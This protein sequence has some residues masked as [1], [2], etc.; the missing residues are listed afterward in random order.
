MTS[1]KDKLDE[2]I[3]LNKKKPFSGPGSVTSR[4]TQQS[5]SRRGGK[6]NRNYQSNRSTVLIKGR[7]QGQGGKFNEASNRNQFWA[8]KQGKFYGQSS[9]LKQYGSTASLGRKV[10]NAAST[11]TNRHYSSFRGRLRYRGQQLARNR[12]RLATQILSR[13]QKNRQQTL[14]YWNSGSVQ[15]G[16]KITSAS[17]GVRGLPMKQRRGLQANRGTVNSLRSDQIIRLQKQQNIQQKLNHARALKSNWLED[18]NS[19]AGSSDMLTVCIPNDLATKRGFTPRSNLVK[20]FG[21]NRNF[22]G[23]YG[24]GSVARRSNKKSNNHLGH[25]S[26]AAAD[27]SSS[28]VD[29][30]P[31]G[32]IVTT[33]S[34]Y[35]RASSVGRNQRAGSVIRGAKQNRTLTVE[36]YVPMTNVRSALN[37]QLQ[38]EIA[39]IQGKTFQLS[40]NSMDITNHASG[41]NTAF[42]LSGFKPV[43]SLTATT[44]NER[45]SL[46]L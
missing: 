45:F 44:L 7:F 14:Q 24:R 40:P 23:K 4:G 1:G 29:I 27:G 43:P 22:K 30:S 10:R 28:V 20:K 16:Y 37:L 33:I 9:L 13:R 34:R 3:K 12:I 39:A 25:Q 26:I 8:Q 5:R 15:G 6:G 38:K 46:A 32:S 36:Q 42:G 11:G 31:E 2:I 18:S 35:S 17:K 41:F 21:G 19:V